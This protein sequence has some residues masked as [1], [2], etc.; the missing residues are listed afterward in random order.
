MTWQEIMTN[1]VWTIELS[2][3]QLFSAF[4]RLVDYKSFINVGELI[5]VVWAI[6]WMSRMGV[7]PKKVEVKTIT[8]RIVKDE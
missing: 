3:R 6:G 4:A 1:L 2:L 8:E 5:V 7:K